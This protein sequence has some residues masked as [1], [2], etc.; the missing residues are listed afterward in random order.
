[1]SELNRNSRRR[2]EQYIVVKIGDEQYG[3]DIA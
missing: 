1:M 2:E 3:L